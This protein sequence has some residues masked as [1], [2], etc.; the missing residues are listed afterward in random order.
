MTCK[1]CEA[2]Y[3]QA[4]KEI[5]SLEQKLAIAV[6]ALEFYEKRDQY[7]PIDISP[8]KEALEKIRGGEK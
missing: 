6:E 2:I 3:T 8:A 5:E 1:F 7:I 4:A